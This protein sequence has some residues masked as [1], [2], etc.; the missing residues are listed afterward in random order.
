MRLP[1]HV[2]RLVAVF[3]GYLTAG[4]RSSTASNGLLAA[5]PITEWWIGLG[6]VA[7]ASSRLP[8]GGR[9]RGLN[10]LCCG[11]GMDVAAMR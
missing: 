4:F 2:Q 1:S 3:E 5:A 10:T 11:T 7:S 6:G 8:A 9:N